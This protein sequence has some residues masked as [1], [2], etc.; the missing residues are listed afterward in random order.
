[1]DLDEMFNE[2]NNLKQ[3][4]SF[5]E[6]TNSLQSTFS[7]DENIDIKQVVNSLNKTNKELA[8]ENSK[9]K[10]EINELKLKVI[11]LSEKSDNIFNISN[12]NNK[13]EKTLK[14]YKFN[15]Y[16]FYGTFSV[17]LVIGSLSYFVFS[18]K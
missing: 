5:C 4:N 6:S 10:D 15:I 7:V 11:R 14:D 13:L 18:K 8:E 3:F 9:L 2:S 16:N 12:F 1:M 17:G